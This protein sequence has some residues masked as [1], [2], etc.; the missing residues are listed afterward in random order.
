M[1]AL[2]NC[3]I[4][5]CSKVAATLGETKGRSRHVGVN[6][7][8]VDRF[9]MPVLSSTFPSSSAGDPIKEQLSLAIVKAPSHCQ[10]VPLAVL[11]VHDK[12]G[13]KQ[14]SSL[15]YSDAGAC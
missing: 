2:H 12:H 11:P 13:S 3:P 6:T 5:C 15:C 10:M 7:T 1:D 8:L 4:M 14:A 9:V